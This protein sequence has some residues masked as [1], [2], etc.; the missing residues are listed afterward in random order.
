MSSIFL[1]GCVIALSAATVVHPDAMSAQ[2]TVRRAVVAIPDS[3]PNTEGNA[4]VIRYADS[5]AGDVI[6]LRRSAATPS[7]LGAAFRLLSTLRAAEPTPQADAVTA[8][9]GAAQARGNRS[10][11]TAYWNSVLGRLGA[12]PTARIGNLGTGRWLAINDLLT[13][14]K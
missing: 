1:R 12:R 8:I 9:T 3:F 6:I 14:Q 4:L 5:A 7:M 2:T 13:P 11:T 10:A